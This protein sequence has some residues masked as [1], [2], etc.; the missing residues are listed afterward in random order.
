MKRGAIAPRSHV[1]IGSGTALQ[2][3]RE[4]SDRH[5]DP[6]PPKPGLGD[7]G[8]RPDWL[9][10]AEDGLEAEAGK[11]AKADRPRPPVL[12]LGA[13]K[14]AAK[15][16]P[17]APKPAATPQTAASPQPAAP[18][19]PP[20]QQGAFKMPTAGAAKV[21]PG[22]A[23]AVQ[24]TP[25][26]RA[27]PLAEPAPPSPPAPAPLAAAPASADPASA[28]N[29]F[30]PAPRATDPDASA[31]ASAGSDAHVPWVEPA[32][33]TKPA[34]RKSFTYAPK[35]KSEPDP[36][37]K[38][39]T[40][41]LESALAKVLIVVVALGVLTVVGFQFIP[42][43]EVSGTRIVEIRKAPKAFDGQVVTV[44]GRVGD[45]F[46]IGPSSAY[47][48]HDGNETLLVFTR[49]AAPDPSKK[50]TVTGTVSTGYLDGK[51][52]LSLFEQQ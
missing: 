29:A 2:E 3:D 44:T 16:K 31:G 40:P 22:A 1:V 36:A 37:A 34:G 21:D 7:S 9:V 17:A 5:D 12:K 39:R 20:S 43:D 25:A 8:P 47:Y 19:V 45:I 51:P 49:G 38:P 23:P 52:R 28:A 24:P 33:K 11:R 30:R 48:L 14:P 15:P 50:H 18:A 13:P 4:Q 27:A 41:F 10:S 6:M 46:Q 32:K 42:R 26:G 35:E